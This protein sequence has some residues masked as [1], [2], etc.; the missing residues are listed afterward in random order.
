M[1]VTGLTKE[2]STVLTTELLGTGLHYSSQVCILVL[3]QVDE[4]TELLGTVLTY[5]CALMCC[6][7]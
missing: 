1:C 5:W 2:M 4:Q 7:R 6:L 3:S